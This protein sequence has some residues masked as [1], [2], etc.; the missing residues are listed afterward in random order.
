MFDQCSGGRSAYRPS[1]PMLT[2]ADI[3]AATMCEFDG[4]NWLELDPW[5][6]GRY[7]RVATIAHDRIKK[8]WIEGAVSID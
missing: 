2:I 7:V 1:R 8:A 5:L 6:R 4:R 3:I